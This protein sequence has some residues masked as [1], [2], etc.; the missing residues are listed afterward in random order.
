MIEKLPHSDVMSVRRRFRHILRYVV[1]EP[2]LA[3]VNQ[4][5]DYRRQDVLGDRGDVEDRLWRHRNGVLDV[6]HTVAAREDNTTITRH[7]DRYSGGVAGEHLLRSRVDPVTE[8]FAGWQL[9]KRGSAVETENH[10][11]K[12]SSHSSGSDS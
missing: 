3:F 7:C 10:C 9:S 2:Q 6:G 12:H 5:Q 4:L 8:L 1:V 11:D